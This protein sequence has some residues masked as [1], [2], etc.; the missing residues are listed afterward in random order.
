MKT[1]KLI[2]NKK[3]GDYYTENLRYKVERGNVGWNVSE[4]DAR[5]WYTYSF[6][7]ETLKEVKESI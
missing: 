5:G 7:C 4:L 3:T 6:S 2:R 1:T